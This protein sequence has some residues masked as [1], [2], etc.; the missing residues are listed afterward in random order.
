MLRSILVGLL[1]ASAVAACSHGGDGPPA[2][3]PGVAVGKVVELT[4]TVTATRGTQTRTL[5][6]SSTVSG[7]DVIT[8]SADGRVAIVLAHNNARWDLGPNKHERVA[9][10]LAWGLARVDHPADVVDVETTSAGRHAERS[11]AAGEAETARERREPPAEP[12]GGLAGPSTDGLVP[13]HGGSAGS[14]PPEPPQVTQTTPLPPPPP[15]PPPPPPPTPKPPAKVERNAAK[16]PHDSKTNIAADPLADDGGNS[17]DD[18]TRNT[19]T[20][21]PDAVPDGKAPGGSVEHKDAK[22]R[23]PAGE[24]PALRAAIDRQRAALRACVVA[25]GVERIAIVFHVV[26]GATTIEVT[27]GTDKDRACFAKI[28]GRIRLAADQ[29]ATYATSVAK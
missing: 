19:V 17:A 27:D 24:P 7:D 4:G 18:V 9:D 10:S 15:A 11:A 12:R 13:G 21:V 8:T 6:A 2:V 25:A 23:P 28:A 29:S 5:D 14:V 22:P 20:A 3:E 16:A 26:N 1:A